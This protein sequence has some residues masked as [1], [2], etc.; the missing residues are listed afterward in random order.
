ML[1]ISTTNYISNAEW[2]QNVVKGTNL[3]L[4]GVSA[5]EYLGLFNGY[6]N[7]SNVQVYTNSIGIYDN[8][9]YA[10][11]KSFDEIDYSNSDGVLCT[12]LNQTV[13]DM[14]SDYDSIDELAFLK[15]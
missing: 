12:T 5:L 1:T 6:V 9:G 11:L 13:N 2:L 10:F 4:R 15:C 8:V 7:E 3:I 14:L